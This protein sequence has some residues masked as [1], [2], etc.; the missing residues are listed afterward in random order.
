[1]PEA[2]PYFDT[3]Q[4]KMPGLTFTP[5]FAEDYVSMLKN[6]AEGEDWITAMVDY[7]K[8]YET[9]WNASELEHIMKKRREGDYS[10]S[11]ASMF[12][13]STLNY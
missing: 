11:V 1:M 5:L 12:S 6:D 9:M 7:Y 3:A 13:N 2:L 10:Y 4:T 8:E